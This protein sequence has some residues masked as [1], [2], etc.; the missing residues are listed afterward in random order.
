VQ[1]K[2]NMVYIKANFSSLSQTITKLETDT[3]LL[4]ETMKEI[5]AKLNKIMA[6]EV[7]A[8]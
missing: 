2:Y 6:L 7:D 3:N 1:A 8:V 4:P 5:N